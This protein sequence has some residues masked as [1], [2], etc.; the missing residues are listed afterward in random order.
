MQRNPGLRY[1]P[2]FARVRSGADAAAILARNPAAN[3][4]HAS[5]A[6]PDSTTHIVRVLLRGAVPS[7]SSAAE[8]F[9]SALAAGDAVN[10][11]DVTALF[12][13]ARI[14]ELARHVALR[15]A[16]WLHVVAG[17]ADVAGQFLGLLRDQLAYATELVL[18]DLNRHYAGVAAAL[19][20]GMPHL[21]T[22]RVVGC[23]GVLGA[24]LRGM[25]NAPSPRPAELLVIRPR[26][27]DRMDGSWLA[28]AAAKLPVA[29]LTLIGAPVDAETVPLLLALGGMRAA[30]SVHLDLVLPGGEWA[31]AFTPPGEQRRAATL[32][33]LFMRDL[34]LG[35]VT[36]NPRLR[37]LYVRVASEGGREMAVQG[38]VD[39]IVAAARAC[40]LLEHVGMAVADAREEAAVDAA[41]ARMPAVPF[42]LEMMVIAG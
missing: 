20:L 39:V 28:Y 14:E 7:A 25:V 8:L 36:N 21:A 33:A 35:V 32:D 9:D 4:L 22:L 31:H 34:L 24:V 6:G 5:A 18:I 27:S 38:A 12:E 26:A 11:V 10:H 19:G 30:E 23:K 13:D 16:E 1:Q 40:P 15:P 17:G 29:A 3:P 2:G 42:E 41:L 37:T